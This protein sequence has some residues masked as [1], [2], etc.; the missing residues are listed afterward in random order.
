[1][2]KKFGLANHRAYCSD[3][4]GNYV[5]LFETVDYRMLMVNAS[6]GKAKSMYPK[7]LDELNASLQSMHEKLIKDGYRLE[8]ESD[9]PANDRKSVAIFFDSLEEQYGLKNDAIPAAE[10]ASR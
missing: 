4:K 5:I 7:S 8:L 1:M 9:I 10:P 3:S 2:K 6:S